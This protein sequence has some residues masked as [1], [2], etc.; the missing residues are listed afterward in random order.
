MDLD[1]TFPIKNLIA[2]H[3]RREEAY[4]EWRAKASTIYHS[5][6]C[7]LF[8]EGSSLFSVCLTNTDVR[9]PSF[10][11]HSYYCSLQLVRQ[12]QGQ[13]ENPFG[14]EA[15]TPKTIFQLLNQVIFTSK[16]T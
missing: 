4:N 16:F 9:G 3:M 6:L 5:S 10:A 15:A 2:D 1:Y 8:L 12:L 7:L 13:D 11:A 14:E